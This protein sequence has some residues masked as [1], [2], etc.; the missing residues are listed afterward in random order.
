MGPSQRPHLEPA[1]FETV[2]DLHCPLTYKMATVDVICMKS[3]VIRKSLAEWA[4]QT[5]TLAKDAVRREESGD[6][7]LPTHSSAQFM[8]Y[9]QLTTKT[10]PS[11]GT[12]AVK[13][14]YV[15]KT[16]KKDKLSGESCWVTENAALRK[17]YIV[18]AE[19]SEFFSHLLYIYSKEIIAYLVAVKEALTVSK[20][21]KKNTEPLPGI[22]GFCKALSVHAEKRG[23]ATVSRFITCV[24]EFI[25]INE[26][27]NNMRGKDDPA[28]AIAEELLKCAP[29]VGRSIR[30][31]IEMCARRYSDF[32]R[33]FA[34]FLGMSLID[35]YSPV[36]ANTLIAQLRTLGQIVASRTGQTGKLVI[37]NATYMDL[38]AAMAREKAKKPSKKGDGLEEDSEALES[39]ED[40]P[41]NLLD[42]EITDDAIEVAPV[43]PPA[44][45]KS[46]AKKGAAAIIA[47]SVV[48]KKPAAPVAKAPVAKAPVAKAPVAKAKAG[49]KK[50]AA[51]AVV[52]DDIADNAL[53]DE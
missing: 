30:P 38:R 7:H 22:D 43:T 29:T 14:T 18:S 5:S 35:D 20:D 40:G 49:A 51:A 13:P 8:S 31:E 11:A 21:P 44:A 47:A 6:Y 19:V 39:L 12:P 15:K 3:S 24:P 34:H 37:M 27:T 2:C 45:K 52:E 41:D 46:A 33:I 26:L 42:E 50:P 48:V 23:T 36:T 1:K 17:Y 4:L 9:T 28:G 10:K 53:P 16:Y 32:V 25:N